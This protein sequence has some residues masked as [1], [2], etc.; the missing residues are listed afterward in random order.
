MILLS[1]SSF[2][3]DSSDVIYTG[4]IESDDREQELETNNGP[5]PTHML[6]V[7]VKRV[8]IRANNY[9][10]WSW[11]RWG[12]KDYLGTILDQDKN[13]NCSKIQVCCFVL[14]QQVK[15]FK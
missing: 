11:S 3:T 14:M 13:R 2:P 12:K 7:R 6:T 9:Q 4:F 5:L 8:E 15:G 10:K 1:D